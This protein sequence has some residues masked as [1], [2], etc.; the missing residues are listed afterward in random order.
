MNTCYNSFKICFTGNIGKA[1]GLDI[2]PKAAKFLKDKNVKFVVIGDGRNRAAFEKTVN[3]NGVKDKFIM[4]GRQPSERISE[5]LGCCDAAFLS[6]MDN[7]LFTKTIPA[8]LQSYMA[9]GMPLIA[10][11]SGESE[12]VIKEAECGV[13]S[14]IGDVKGS[15]ENIL[16]IR[17]EDIK[18]M[19]KRSREYFES[20]F[21]KEKLM[22]EIQEYFR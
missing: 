1:Q 16:N 18:R 4:V 11:A 5:L 13:C 19:R 10:S 15:V 12:R 8:K 20:H 17:E 14:P 2:L 22:D 9:C 3:D 7:E 21:L 6:F